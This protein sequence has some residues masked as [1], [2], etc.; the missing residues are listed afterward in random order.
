MTIGDVAA[1]S[2]VFVTLFA[3]IW[4]TISARKLMARQLFLQ[5][6]AQ[7]ESEVMQR[8][9]AAFARRLIDDVT[10]TTDIDDTVL[11]FLE[12]LASMLHEKL[13]DRELIWTTFSIDICTYWSKSEKYIKRVRQKTNDSSLFDELERAYNELRPKTN[14]EVIEY[15]I[16]M[17]TLRSD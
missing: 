13:I 9:R 2:A 6:Y 16:Y 8:K 11:V 5:L 7:Y 15:Y 1:I 17:E 4:Q 12:T 10:G 3:V 14:D